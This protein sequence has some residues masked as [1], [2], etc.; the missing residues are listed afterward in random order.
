M[1]T[2]DY[3]ALCAE[4]LAAWE[5]GDDIV[6]AMNR[7]RTALAQP[8]DCNY[9][10]CVDDSP[11]DRCSRWLTGD[12]Q[13][14]DSGARAALAVEEAGPTDEA[15]AS[16]AAWFCR[17]Y[18]G[19]NTIICRPEWHA[20]KV[21]R[22]AADAVD[23]ARLALAEGDGVGVTEQ[24]WDALKDRLWSHY[25]TT[26]YQGERFIYQADFDTALDVARKELARYPRYRPVPA[27]ERMPIAADCDMWGR[28]WLEMNSFIGDTI[29]PRW[30]L[31]CPLDVLGWSSW[32]PA[33]AIP[34]PE[35]PGD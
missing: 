31:E 9:P 14:P 15:Q 21:F 7:A 34:L 20:P 4:M 30:S 27:E 11:D 18:P 23:R 25:E 1:T 33:A 29:I 28:C 16:F 26:G 12:C 32:L 22:A 6:G 3:K 35:E 13:G 19:P 17:N 24:D 10:G 8:G 2:P 5:K